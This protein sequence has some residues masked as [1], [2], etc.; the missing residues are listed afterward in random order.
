MII[1]Y[2]CSFRNKAGQ[3]A[4]QLAG[5]ANHSSVVEYLSSTGKFSDLPLP[6][7][8]K[9]P[10]CGWML[11]ILRSYSRHRFEFRPSGDE[12]YSVARSCSS[13]HT[14]DLDGTIE[15]LVEIVE[16]SSVEEVFSYLG[17]ISFGN[18]VRLKADLRK[19]VNKTRWNIE[20]VIV[21]GNNIVQ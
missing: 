14:H 9:I 2:N 3:T 6:E 16:A 5:Q 19:I 20:P 8:L 7:L 15:E 1:Y 12:K 4:L 17:E 11:S 10:T 18:A 13:L 21:I